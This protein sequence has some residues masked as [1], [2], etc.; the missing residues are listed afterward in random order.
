MCHLN[1]GLVHPAGIGRTCCPQIGGRRLKLRN[2]RDRPRSDHHPVVWP[3]I[4]ETKSRIDAAKISPLAEGH[5]YRGPIIVVGDIDH[6]HIPAY[7]PAV[8][9]ISV[10]DHDFAGIDHSGNHSHVAERHA[11]VRRKRQNGSWFRPFAAL[12]EA[13]CLM[14]PRTGISRDRYARDTAGVCHALQ[15]TIG[16]GISYTSRNPKMMSRSRG[17]Q[18]PGLR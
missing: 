18:I 14:P 3:V 12:I 11:A 16:T 5:S 15:P 8:A 13:A 9:P 10:I 7:P 4:D 1:I 17:V 2:W 6:R